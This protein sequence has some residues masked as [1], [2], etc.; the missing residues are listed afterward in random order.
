LLAQLNAVIQA[1]QVIE[2]KRPGQERTSRG[3][4]VEGGDR[5]THLFEKW[6]ALRNEG[7]ELPADALCHDDPDLIGELTARIAKASSQT[8][9][10]Q[11]PP[12][13]SKTPVSTSTTDDTL[14][15]Y[16]LKQFLGKGGFGEVWEAYDPV[17]DKNVAIKRPRRD[18]TYSERQIEAFLKEARKAASLRHPG[19][20]AVHNAE[21]DVSGWYI[22]SDL[23][24]GNSLRKHLIDHAFSAVESARLVAAIAEALHAAHLQGL[25]HR[26]IKFD[27]ILIDRNQQPYLTDFGLAISEEEQVDE[28][29]L[30]AGTYAYM[31]PEQIRGESQHLDGRSD[32]YSLGVVLYRLLTKRLPFRAPDFAGYREQILERAPRP[33][34]SIDDS[35]AEELERICLK[36]MAKDVTQRYTTA[37]D[38]ASDLRQWLADQKTAEPAIDNLRRVSR[39]RRA[40][41]Y[42]AMGGGLLLLAWIL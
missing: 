36:C 1:L 25:I 22:V 7:L 19:I 42:L 33:P 2:G 4:G 31:S 34:R 26:D 29:D 23:V 41:P 27:N 28:R 17:L 39:T 32:I 10:M 18:R 12:S 6:C 40:A 35:I 20:V 3:T 30:V 16:Q 11:V 15:R 8:I 21:R 38:L 24:D 14:G 9:S 37:K 13:E 5:V